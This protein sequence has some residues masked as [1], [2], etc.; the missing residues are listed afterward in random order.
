MISI[1]SASNLL[2]VFHRR[3]CWWFR[4]PVEYRF[5][6]IITLLIIAMT[7]ALS[8][9]IQHSFNVTPDTF[10]YGDSWLGGMFPIFV[11][12][13]GI[14]LIFAVIIT[15]L[16][17]AAFMWLSVSSIVALA[18][19]IHDRVVSLKARGYK[20]SIQQNGKHTKEAA[21]LARRNRIYAELSATT[22][23]KLVPAKRI[24]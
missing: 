1:L 19:R 22:K 20:I 18:S 8:V 10:P 24:T 23:Y 14:I 17:I 16:L 2:P 12:I 13:Y 6:A 11:R 4:I 9:S 3:N 7:A 5:L 21:E 15:G